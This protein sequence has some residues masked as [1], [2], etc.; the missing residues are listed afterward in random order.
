M[1]PLA[2]RKNRQ[3]VADEQYSG[4]VEFRVILNK[5]L[6]SVFGYITVV[7]PGSFSTYL[8]ITLQNNVTGEGPLQKQPRGE[9]MVSLL[10]Y[11]AEPNSDFCCSIV[12]KQISSLRT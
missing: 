1:S 8:F 10:F 2:L 12:L 11:H 9:K 3:L 5:L 7:L 6:E 4:G